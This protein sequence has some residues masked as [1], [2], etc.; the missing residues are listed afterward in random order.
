MAVDATTT[1]GKRSDVMASVD[2][3]PGAAEFV[4]A[5]ISRDDAWLSVRLTDAFGLD[6]WR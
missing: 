6:D 5:D 3:G 1:G 4:I 2:D